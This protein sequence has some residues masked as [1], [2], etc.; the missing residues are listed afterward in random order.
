MWVISFCVCVSN[1]MV[2][3]SNAWEKFKW[4]NK[5]YDSVGFGRWKSNLR[6]N[7]NTMISTIWLAPA[8]KINWNMLKKT[9]LMNALGEALKLLTICICLKTEL[10]QLK[11]DMVHDSS[12]KFNQLLSIVDCKSVIRATLRLD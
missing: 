9:T 7:D 6:D 11:M 1:N 3:K 12:K 10:Y 8:P 4:R 5:F 2:Y